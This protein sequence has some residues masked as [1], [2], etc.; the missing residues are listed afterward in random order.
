M[1]KFNLE[2]NS[3]LIKLPLLRLK[4]GNLQC[5]DTMP[6]LSAITG[7]KNYVQPQHLPQLFCLQQEKRW[8]PK[9]QPSGDGFFPDV[10]KWSAWIS[11]D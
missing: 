7:S 9:S 11:L 8:R 5:S 1:D 2:Q 3:V 4:H 6:H 10:I